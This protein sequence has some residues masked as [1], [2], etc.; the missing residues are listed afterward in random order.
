M[1]DKRL[2]K[3]VPKAR[4]LIAVDVFLQWIA[5]MANIAVFVVI[6]FFLQQGTAA[7]SLDDLKGDS[8]TLPTSSDRIVYRFSV[9][10][11]SLKTTIAIPMNIRT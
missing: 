4:F 6:G 8:E 3:L 7:A 1:F 10:V 5:L 2:L 11:K 9:F